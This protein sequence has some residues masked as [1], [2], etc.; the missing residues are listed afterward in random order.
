M[1]PNFEK[2]V[3]ESSPPNGAAM[4]PA[5]PLASIAVLLIIVGLIGFAAA[6]THG[7]NTRAWEAFLVNLLFWL[8]VAQGGVVLSAAFYL[9]QGRWAGRAHYR[10]AEAFSGFLILGF[11]LFWALY[12]GRIWIFPWIRHPIPAKSDWLNVPFLF[13]RDGIA[14]FVMT[15]LSLWFVAASRSEATRKWAE[16]TANIV[17]PPKAVRRL[18]PAV[19]IC[20]AAVYT[21][22]SF[23]LIMSL[24]PLWRSTLFG[25]WYFAG[26]F[27]S[28]T[29]MIA[30][31]ACLLRPVLGAGNVFTRGQ[32]LHDMGKMIFAFS[33]FWVYTLFAQ[34]IVIWYGDIPVETFF[35]VVRTQ[36]LPWAFLSWATLTLVWILPFFVLLGIRPKRTPAILGAIAFLGIC[37]IWIENYVLVVPSLSPRTIPFGWVEILV[38]AGF[39]GAFWLCSYPG[40]KLASIAATE[41]V[42]ELH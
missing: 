10:L 11:I 2:A 18:A 38:T 17:M 28:A 41:P 31:T 39:L 26:D 33:I 16:T 27:W 15:V 32:V 34:Y 13:A 29:V 22:L 9:T 37:G 5:Q 40:L 12:F 14:L 23:D 1:S 36:Y 19:A 24:S 25:W 21:L 7:A 42:P 4:L 30:F 3:A 6:I 20:F 35:I 8:G